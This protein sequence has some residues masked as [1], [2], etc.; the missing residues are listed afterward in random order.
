MSAALGR[1]G[2]GFCTPVLREGLISR[3]RGCFKGWRVRQGLGSEAGPD[4]RP[5]GGRFQM[6]A[7]LLVKIYIFLKRSEFLLLHNN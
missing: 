5:Q 6:R 4:W 2:R 1:G 3:G 7:G